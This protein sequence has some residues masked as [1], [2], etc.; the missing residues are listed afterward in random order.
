MTQ[1]DLD[2]QEKDVPVADAS[3]KGHNRYI[4]LRRGNNVVTP[5]DE[6]IQTYK[7]LNIHKESGE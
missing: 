3:E 7:K 4:R 2:K 1:P 5:L 6:A